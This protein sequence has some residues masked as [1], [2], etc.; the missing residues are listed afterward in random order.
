MNEVYGTTT[1]LDIVSSVIVATL[2][3]QPMGDRL[4]YIDLVEHRVGILKTTSAPGM[5][6]GQRQTHLADAGGVDDDFVDFTHF[7]EELFDSRAFQDIRIVPLPFDF[8][9][10][11]KVVLWHHLR[12]KG[13]VVFGGAEITT[14][15]L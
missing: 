14:I 11:G 2:S 8:D 7:A 4:V 3:E 1:D 15:V 5:P 10:D 9:R 12:R 13:S 6:R